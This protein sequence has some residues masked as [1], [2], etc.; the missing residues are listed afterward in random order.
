M[1]KKQILIIDD[2][3]DVRYGLNMRLRAGF[4]TSLPSPA[5]R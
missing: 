3:A 2:D 4:G 1:A 5:H